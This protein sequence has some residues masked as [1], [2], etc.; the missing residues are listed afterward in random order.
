MNVRSALL[1][2][3][4]LISGTSFLYEIVRRK[5]CARYISPFPSLPFPS[6]VQSVGVITMK[7]L[8]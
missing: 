4:A 3:L 5:Q 2:M 7:R 6:Q 8:N 1:A